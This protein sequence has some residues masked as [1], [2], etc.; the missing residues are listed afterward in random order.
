MDKSLEMFYL[1]F[2]HGKLRGEKRKVNEGNNELTIGDEL[3]DL[4][5]RKNETFP[6]L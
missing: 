4:F 5:N 6:V 2:N 3:V 1:F